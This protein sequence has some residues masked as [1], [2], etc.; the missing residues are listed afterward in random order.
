MSGMRRL[1]FR[2]YWPL[3][4]A[5]DRF[6]LRRLMQLHPGLEIHPEASTNLV[7][8]E[9]ELAPGARLRIGKG[10]V[11]ER[12]RHA[13][14]FRIGEGG[15]INIGENTWLYTDL[16]T[17]HLRAFDN[18][19]LLIAPRGWLHACHLSA[20]KRMEIGENT[21]IGPGSR[22]LDSDQHALDDTKPEQTAAIRI[23]AHT[24]IS[25]D[26]FVMK[27][28]EIGSHCVIGARSLVNR[29]IPDHSLAFGT[30]ARVHG[31][32]GDRSKV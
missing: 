18:A 27:G 9:F 15:E 8:A 13:V 11:T 31:P 25:S 19:Q 32:V 16:G 4:Q 28:V 20:K 2:I 1:W 5:W 3:L 22:V 7:Q 24:W 12:R 23:G 26:V 10:V 6:R 30:P 17:M 29:S 14:R 21:W